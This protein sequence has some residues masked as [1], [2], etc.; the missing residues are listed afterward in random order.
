[1]IFKKNILFQACIIISFTS[2]LHATIQD[3]PSQPPIPALFAATKSSYCL[4]STELNAF[5][6]KEIFTKQTD[7]RLYSKVSQACLGNGLISVSGDDFIQNGRK[8]YDFG[9]HT[10]FYSARKGDVAI[11]AGIGYDYDRI[12][13]VN[14]SEKF[15]VRGG[16]ISD[17]YRYLSIRDWEENSLYANVNGSLKIDGTKRYL[18]GIEMNHTAKNGIEYNETAQY[19]TDGYRDFQDNI[20]YFNYGDGAYRNQ[21]SMGAG[22]LKECASKRGDERLIVAS[23]IYNHEK[24]HSNMS[25]IDNLRSYFSITPDNI[26]FSER[27]N[28]LNEIELAM[29]L[30]E[31]VPEQL[32]L[33]VAQYPSARMYSKYLGFSLQYSSIRNTVRSFNQWNMNDIFYAT[34]IK[35]SMHY[36]LSLEIKNCTDLI[37]FRNFRVR[38]DTHFNGMIELYSGQKVGGICELEFLPYL[39]FTFLLKNTLLFD[40]NYTPTPVYVN[41]KGMVNSHDFGFEIPLRNV[42]QLRIAILK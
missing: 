3:D 27:N 42:F 35:K 5:F 23:M 34:Q 22:I 28:S 39:G 17:N 7:L 6:N 19:S 26:Q 18:L 30:S 31:R 10:L 37:L 21:F 1:M 38:F 16:T 24:E 4:V 2:H 40:V 14:I 8:K 32:F 12:K 33:N 20:T 13:N 41:Y 36:P 9:P 25:F 29:L 11:G 15:D